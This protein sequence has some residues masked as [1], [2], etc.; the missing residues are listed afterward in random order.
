[1]RPQLFNFCLGYKQKLRALPLPGEPGRSPPHTYRRRRVGRTR[2]GVAPAWPSIGAVTGRLGD[3]AGKSDSATLRQVR[4]V[5]MARRLGNSAAQRLGENEGQIAALTGGDSSRA[6][7][8]GRRSREPQTANPRPASRRGARP[9]SAGTCSG[10]DRKRG[11]RVEAL[12]SRETPT[13]QFSPVIQATAS[14]SIASRGRT[15]PVDLD[16][17]DRIRHA[18]ADRRDESFRRHP[19]GTGASIR[20]ES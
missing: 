18:E 19:T 20:F 14:T 9:G 3:S 1:M 8:P 16:S 6:R 15:L 4:P 5:S 2:N 17:I 11:S 13:F 10:L 12:L 7:T